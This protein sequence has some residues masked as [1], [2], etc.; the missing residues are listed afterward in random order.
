MACWYREVNISVFLIK[1]IVWINFSLLLI[2]LLTG[3]SHVHFMAAIFCSLEH[4]LIASIVCEVIKQLLTSFFFY[5][6]F[7]YYLLCIT[8]LLYYLLIK[9]LAVCLFCLLQILLHC[10]PYYCT[11]VSNLL[12]SYA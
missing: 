9:F 3:T 8:L 2:F 1:V 6:T 5:Y 4:V 11:I 12:L 10:C 7:I